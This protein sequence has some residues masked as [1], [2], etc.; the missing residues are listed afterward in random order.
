MIK[1][2]FILLAAVLFISCQDNKTKQHKTENN[3]K[4]KQIE[5][6]IKIEEE[7]DDSA[8]KLKAIKKIK[9]EELIPF[10]EKYGEEN[11]EKHVKIKTDFGEIELELFTDT[12]LHRANFIYLAKL[13]YFDTTFFYRVDEGFVIQAGNSDNK[14]TSRMRKAIGS[15]LI[16]KEFKNHYKND[17]GYL[18]AAKYS[19]Q[20]VS[21]ASSP[22]EFY[23]VMDKNG[24][25]HLN[26]EHTVFGK[27][28]KGMDVAEE[29]SKVETGKNSEIPLKNIEI[30]VEI[31][32]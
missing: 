26:Q 18:A 4:E 6:K 16:P 24:A 32:D 12:P 15:F 22:Y 28:L 9:Q 10:L 27:V 23:I 5:K 19:E 13:G 17:Y 31:L 7:I 29:I 1:K 11:P 25:P 2:V 8:E 30:K 21:K 14:I 3:Q 20:N